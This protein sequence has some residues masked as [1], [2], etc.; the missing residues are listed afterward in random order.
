MGA[1]LLSLDLSLAEDELAVLMAE[2]DANDNGLL[3][4]SEF[5]P[6]ATDLITALRARSASRRRVDFGEEFLR[7]LAAE[8][9][10]ELCALVLNQLRSKDPE[11][12]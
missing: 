5:L 12:K 8:D 9:L 2:V 1:L 11:N 10:D 6:L 7:E 4:L 3:D